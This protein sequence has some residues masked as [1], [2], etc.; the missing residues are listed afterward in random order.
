MFLSI[1]SYIHKLQVK[2]IYDI[3]GLQD[4]E[5]KLFKMYEKNFTVNPPGRAFYERINARVST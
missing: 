4:R 3:P 1:T 2:D 5:K